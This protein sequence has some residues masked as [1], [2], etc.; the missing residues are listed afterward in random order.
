[1]V[2]VLPSLF[3]SF[4]FPL[5]VFLFHHD[6]EV[7][8]LANWYW[9]IFPITGSI[10]LF[11]LS[12]VI[13]PF[14]ANGQVEAVQGRST[15]SLN[16]LGGVMATLSAA[17]Y[18]FMLLSSPLPISEVF[19]PK[20]FIELPKDSLTATF[21]LFQYDYIVTAAAV[22]LWLVYSFGDLKNAGICQLS[23]G[24][25]LL[26]SIAIGLLGGPGALIWA[27]WLTRENTMAKLE[28]AKMG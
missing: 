18:W 28:H 24:R 16:F 9:Q 13:R 15:T 8:H 5:G 7:K 2:A 14:V 6:L 1:M 4:L 23:W 19:I 22:L 11:A 12:I 10:L 27:G 17:S 21:T 20:F 3:A 26:S 25:I